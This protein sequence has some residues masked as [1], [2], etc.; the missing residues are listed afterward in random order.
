MTTP[1]RELKDAAMNEEKAKELDA[2]L[3][4]EGRWGEAGKLCEEAAE[5]T[6]NWHRSAWW[7]KRGCSRYNRIRDW[8]AFVRCHR[9]IRMLVKNDP[10]PEH[11]LDAWYPAGVATVYP[12]IGQAENAF[13]ELDGIA[14]EIGDNWSVYGRFLY[15][16]ARA[17]LHRE[18]GQWQAM[19]AEGQRFMEWAEKLSTDAPAYHRL[20]P[21]I[22]EDPNPMLAG[23]S[24]LCYCACSVL[25]EILI[26]S[27]QK[28][29]QDS[30][31]TFD[32]LTR[33]LLRYKSF[34]EDT[35][36]RSQQDM[37]NEDLRELTSWLQRRVSVCY[38]K[39]AVA[40]YEVKKPERAVECFNQ[41]EKL[42]GSIESEW[43]LYRVASLI[44]ANRLQ[45]AKQLLL[46][47]H[48]SI[49]S[50]GRARSL[51]D[52]LPEFAR[53]KDDEEIEKFTA[54]WKVV[55]GI[56]SSCPPT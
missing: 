43:Q 4:R 17:L 2:R 19:R 54:Q 49:L 21:H 56:S 10:N 48:G 12:H 15:C 1:L 35:A 55:P 28:M 3:R 42:R 45:E 52:K 11:R 13:T 16:L 7:L 34:A 39:A 51:Y 9:K 18:L 25:T 38:G 26:V 31:Q 27:E 23:E 8:Q 40:A 24:G 32:A 46:N 36:R 30:S 14:E 5:A 33:W 20:H 47:T 41:S 37:N 44:A 53:I 29:R 6:P 50:D 22:D